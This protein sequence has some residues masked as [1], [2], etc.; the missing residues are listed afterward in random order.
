MVEI[1]KAEPRDGSGGNKMGG[2]DPSSAW[3]PPQAPMG[4]MQGPNGQM[5]GPPMNLGAPMGPNMMQ[6]PPVIPRSF[7]SN[8]TRPGM[9][10]AQ[11]TQNQLRPETITSTNNTSTRNNIDSRVLDCLSSP[12]DYV[13][14]VQ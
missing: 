10:Y 7:V 4:M 12:N 9:S 2:S 14:T 6:K 8:T 11:A 1:K 13:Q 3:G 5:G